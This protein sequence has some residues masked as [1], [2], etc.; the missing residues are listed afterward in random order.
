[1]V[2]FL[3]RQHVDTWRWHHLRATKPNGPAGLGVVV[4][5][6]AALFCLTLGNTFQIT[7]RNEEQASEA[8][9]NLES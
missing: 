2:P 9:S 6:A 5:A 4:A 3:L 8:G 7:G 1:M